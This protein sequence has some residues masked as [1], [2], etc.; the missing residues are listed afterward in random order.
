MLPIR[1]SRNLCMPSHSIHR[2]LDPLTFET[3]A[4]AVRGKRPKAIWVRPRIEV[5]VSYRTITEAGM[6]R[7]AVWKGPWSRHPSRRR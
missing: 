6:L 5:D 7:H 2:K 3:P 4:V 1:D